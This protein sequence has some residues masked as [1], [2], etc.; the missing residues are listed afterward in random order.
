M[1]KIDC[2]EVRLSC[3]VT[4]EGP[5][6]VLLHG[7]PESHHSWRHQVPVLSQNCR[8]AVPDLRG[9]GN[10]DRPAAVADYAVP[11]LVEDIAGLIRALGYERATIVGHDWGGA[12]AW[13]FAALHPEMTERVAVLNCPHPVNLVEA[14]RG[15]PRQLLRSGYVFFFQLPWL[16]ETILR[17][18][19]GFLVQSFR[20]SAVQ[21]DAFRQADL[22]VFRRELSR[23]GLLRAGI[24]WYRA[25]FRAQ[26][27]LSRYGIKVE[28]LPMI[29]APALLLWGTGDRF[30]GRELT[31]GTERH[32]RQ[33]RTV[34]LDQC[35][36]W[37]QQE[38]PERVNFLLLEFI[39][40]TG[41]ASKPIS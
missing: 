6:V 35:G 23:P 38:Q 30:L 7:F 31:E 12:L 5:L 27:G 28:S 39:G 3:Q 14:V 2:G 1:Q 15:N 8:V 18:G 19:S 40:Q 24:D 32:V 29:E 13:A 16:P 37:T 9:Y 20:W 22:A 4:G 26:L 33:L 10:S 41:V 36:H 17:L 34:Y 25:G 11:K 21:K